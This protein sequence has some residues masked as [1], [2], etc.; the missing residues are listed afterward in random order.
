MWPNNYL[1][2][3]N[4]HFW[5][6]VIHLHVEEFRMKSNILCSPTASSLVLQTQAILTLSFLW[7]LPQKVERYVLAYTF[8]LN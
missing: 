1:Y 8:F 7:C 5:L 6:K 4:F 2:V 3:L